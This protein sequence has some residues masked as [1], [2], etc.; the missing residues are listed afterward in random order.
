MP[1]A[2]IYEKSNQAF[3]SHRFKWCLSGCIEQ[4][5]CRAAVY[6]ARFAAG[7]AVRFSPQGLSADR[8]AQHALLQYYNTVLST[9]LSSSC[10]VTLSLWTMY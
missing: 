2:T 4:G 3:W 10:T 6:K 7:T 5:L 8:S 1:I 9:G